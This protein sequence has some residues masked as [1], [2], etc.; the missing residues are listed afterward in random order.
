MILWDIAGLWKILAGIYVGSSIKVPQ[1]NELLP[2]MWVIV[3]N[4]FMVLGQN[5]WENL[6]KNPCKIPK[7]EFMGSSMKVPQFNKLLSNTWVII[8]NHFTF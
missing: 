3:I 1:F 8:I 5:K 4:R 2:N 6:C 7:G